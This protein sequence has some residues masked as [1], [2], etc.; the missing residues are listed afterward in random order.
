MADIDSGSDISKRGDV[1]LEI[2]NA[3]V[4]LYKEC[5]GRGPTKARTIYQGDVVVCVLRGGLTV[6]ER[7]LYERGR[8]ESVLRLRSEFQEAVR[9]R[10]TDAVEE[11]VGRNVIGFMSG[12]QLDP[13]MSVEVFVLEPVIRPSRDGGPPEAAARAA[14]G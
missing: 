14:E 3:I 10:F 4:R 11:I 6:A 7:T 13:E 1:L 12:S 2:S 5:F 9:E 8:G